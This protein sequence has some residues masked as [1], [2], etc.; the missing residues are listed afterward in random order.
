MIIS[1][2]LSFLGGTAFRMIWGEVAS[3]F[4]ERQAHAQEMDMLKLQAEIDA[5]QHARNLEAIRLQAELGVKTI[6]VQAE[7]AISQ[8]EVDAWRERVKNIEQPSGIWIVD[9]WK[10]LIQPVLATVCLVLVVLHFHRNGW[11]LDERGWELC[12]AVLGLYVAD[13]MLFRRGK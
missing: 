4:S 6:Q 1:T 10:G 12:G 11:Q 8:I 2:L 13:R 5:G 3:W 9:L 7:A